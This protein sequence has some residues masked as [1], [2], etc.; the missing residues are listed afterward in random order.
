MRRPHPFKDRELWSYFAVEKCAKELLSRIYG[1]TAERR[2]IKLA[3]GKEKLVLF[4]KTE[5]GRFWVLLFNRK[6]RIEKAHIPREFWELQ[7]FKL[8]LSSSTFCRSLFNLMRKRGVDYRILNWKFYEREYP[9]YD[10]GSEEKARRY[11]LVSWHRENH[12]ECKTKLSDLTEKPN[13]NLYYF[14]CCETVYDPLED[15]VKDP[16]SQLSRS[17]R[18]AYGEKYFNQILYDAWMQKR[19][20]RRVWSPHMFMLD[21]LEREETSESEREISP[22]D[23]VD[24][25][26]S[27]YQEPTFSGKDPP[28]VG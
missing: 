17:P 4:F 14:G 3:S 23:V 18:I 22:L 2:R 12:P 20:R 11:S 7:G 16:H 26:E 21:R 9:N 13:W 25:Q 24:S 28:D 5:K 1:V 6:Y 8:I 19:G 27:S 10:R 15:L